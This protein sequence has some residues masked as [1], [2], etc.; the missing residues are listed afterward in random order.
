MLAPGKLM[1]WRSAGGLYER[2]DGGHYVRAAG[3]GREKE[4]LFIRPARWK[5]LLRLYVGGRHRNEGGYWSGGH[6]TDIVEDVVELEAGKCQAGEREKGENMPH[7]S[8]QG[9]TYAR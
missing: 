7:T 4:P 3:C 2:E 1:A 5:R 9:K 8:F 6:Y